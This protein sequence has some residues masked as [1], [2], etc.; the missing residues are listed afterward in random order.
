[1]H[2]LINPVLRRM[3]TGQFRE[4]A[5]SHLHLINPDVRPR[6]EVCEACV[7]LGDSWPALRMC[8]VCGHVGCCDQSKN[9]H[10]FKHFQ[11][12]GHPLTRPYRERGM[13]WMWCYEDEALLDPR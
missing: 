7:A 9:R 5:C 4:K 12:T 6:A 10:A 13:N 2:R 11:E 3:W 1:M 8:L